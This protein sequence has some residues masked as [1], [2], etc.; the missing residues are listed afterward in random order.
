MLHKCNVYHAIIVN[1][2]FNSVSSLR[3]RYPNFTN[4]FLLY[5]FLKQFSWLSNVVHHRIH[6]YFILIIIQIYV[7][8]DKKH[9]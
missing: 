3:Q 4:N 6:H 5:I 7:G 9:I 8:I 2:N 1:F